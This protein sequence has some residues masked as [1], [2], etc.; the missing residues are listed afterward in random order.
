MIDVVADVSLACL[1]FHEIPSICQ[2]KVM[3]KLTETILWVQHIF[4]IM[5]F[6]YIFI[7]NLILEIM[8][9]IE[10]FEI[11]TLLVY[12]LFLYKIHCQKDV[13]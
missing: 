12:Y 2:T 3:L 8:E 11:I 10:K 13:F 6:A 7:F 1:Q 9:E 5:Q 4:H